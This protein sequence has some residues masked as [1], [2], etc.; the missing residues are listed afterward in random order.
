VREPKTT[1]LREELEKYP[2]EVFGQILDTKRPQSLHR[3][4]LEGMAGKTSW[5][6]GDGGSAAQPRLARFVPDEHIANIEMYF[7]TG[8]TTELWK[9]Q[10][11]VDRFIIKNSAAPT[12]A[13]VLIDRPLPSTPRVFTRGNPLTKGDAVPTAVPE[14]L[15]PQKPFTKWQRP[16]GTRAGHHRSRAIRSPPASW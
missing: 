4:S 3:A 1:S 10:G 9:S 11:D 12:H 2:E 16:A 14:P 5:R 7:P 8:V 6:R 13:T 15:R